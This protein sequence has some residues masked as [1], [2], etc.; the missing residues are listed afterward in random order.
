MLASNVSLENENL[1]SGSHCRK[2]ERQCQRQPYFQ[3]QLPMSSGRVHSTQESVSNVP[4]KLSSAM[5]QQG[6]DPNTRHRC[7]H[8]SFW[9]WHNQLALLFHRLIHHHLQRKISRMR[10]MYPR[11]FDPEWTDVSAS[12]DAGQPEP[13]HK[14]V[15]IND[16]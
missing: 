3:W 11:S 9:S 2:D 5:E 12:S 13:F 15:Q 4:E 10:K 16:S 6:P 7:H 1:S 14:A 8:K